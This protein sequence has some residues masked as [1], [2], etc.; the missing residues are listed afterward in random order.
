MTAHEGEAAVAAVHGRRARERTPA[1]SEMGMYL[2]RRLAARAADKRTLQE[3]AMS[4][5][6]L[7]PAVLSPASDLPP[8]DVPI[9]RNEPESS[10]NI[11]GGF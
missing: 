4:Q 1:M 11:S 6:L 10:L 7:S 2:L 9:A 8:A 5:T 3:A